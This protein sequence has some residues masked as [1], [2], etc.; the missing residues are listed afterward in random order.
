[1]LTRNACSVNQALALAAG[2]GEKRTEEAQKIAGLI[3]A[4]GELPVANVAMFG[5]GT[6]RV[7]LAAQQAPKTV[8]F[9][10]HTT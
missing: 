6:R 7:C 10:R 4:F 5:G 2:R 3:S 1:M 8:G 9:S